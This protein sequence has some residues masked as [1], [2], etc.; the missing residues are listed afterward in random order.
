MFDP[1]NDRRRTC[2]R[3]GSRVQLACF[4]T[5]APPPS[6]GGAARIGSSSAPSAAASSAHAAPTPNASW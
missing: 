2:R 1:L 3:G 4:A 5:S 6:D